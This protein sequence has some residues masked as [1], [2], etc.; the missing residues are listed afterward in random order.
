VCDILNKVDTIFI[1]FGMVSDIVFVLCILI[2]IRC[3]LS[4]EMN[5]I[6]ES[7]VM[8]LTLVFFVYFKK[9]GMFYL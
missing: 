6:I 5:N 1:L 4:K 2:R 7:I 9:G 3:Y 8:A